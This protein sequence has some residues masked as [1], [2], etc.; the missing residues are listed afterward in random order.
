MKCKQIVD[1]ENTLH[2]S[3]LTGTFAGLYFDKHGLEHLS[4]LEH[5]K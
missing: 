2:L 3:E 4:D 5:D 1:P